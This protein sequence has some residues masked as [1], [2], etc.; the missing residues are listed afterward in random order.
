MVFAGA[1]EYPA[2]V[3]IHVARCGCVIDGVMCV[4]FT[5]VPTRIACRVYLSNV[6]HIYQGYHVLAPYFLSTQVPQV[7]VSRFV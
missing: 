7:R 1:T 5:F 4:K 3:Q 6:N 2:P